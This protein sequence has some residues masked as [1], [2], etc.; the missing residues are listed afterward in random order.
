MARQRRIQRIAPGIWRDGNLKIAEVRV[1]SSRDGNQER[2]REEFP[3]S[4]ATNTMIAWRL[5]T[6]AKFLKTRP[7]AGT[8]RGTLAADVPT[9]L[10]TLPEGRYRNDSKTIRGNRVISTMTV[11]SAALAL[12]LDVGDFAAGGHFAIPADHT[13]TSECGEAEKP[14]ETHD[15]PPIRS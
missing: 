3:L 10:A 2:V 4:T 5:S 7:A 12:L 13:P 9:Y 15:G 6:K 11:A 1:G 14:N 8:A